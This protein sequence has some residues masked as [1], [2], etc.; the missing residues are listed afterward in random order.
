[1]RG[2][3]ENLVSRLQAKRCGKGWLAKC[4]AHDDH[5]PSLRIDEG[6]G[7]CALVRCWAGC[8]LDAVLSAIGLTKKDLFPLSTL[9]KSSGNGEPPHSTPIATRFDW[10]KCVDAFTDTH[11]EHVAK[12]RGFSPEFVREFRDARLI[13]IFNG[14]VAFPVHDRAGNVVAVHY[15][16]K[17]GSWRYYPQ[18]AKVRP[19]VI[20]ELI[21]GDPVHVFESYWDAFAFMDVSGERSG[22]II[23][24]GASNGALVAD[25]IP[26]SSIVYLWT[27]NDA[28]GE[29]WQKDICANTKATVK[30]AN[31][32]A[33]HKDLN[34]W[35]KTNATAD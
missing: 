30:R 16:L 21:A 34:G 1:M 32:P 22:I 6:A 3:V 2:P 26:E 29:K 20:G 35:T 15:R 10:Q 8:T 24:R 5:K 14:L 7:G 11:V 12:W 9:P 13:G 18:G 4:P 19:L 23:T 31:I 25:V 27:Q 17:D 28:P 33:P